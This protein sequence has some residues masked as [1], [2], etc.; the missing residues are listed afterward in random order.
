MAGPISG[1][2]VAEPTV[3]EETMRPVVR[4]TGFR[5]AAPAPALVAIALLVPLALKN[6]FV[7]GILTDCL[8]YVVLALSYDLS[9]GRIGALSLAQPAFFGTGAY[10]AAILVTH[11]PGAP[12]VLQVLLA[13]AAAAVLAVA[14]GIPAFRL[15][16]LTFGMATLGFAIIAELIAQ[17]EVGL[18]N[19]PLCV[20]GVPTMQ[21]SFLSSIG[22][23]SA[24]Q[25][26]EIFLVLAVVA[27]AFIWALVKSRIGRA[28]IAVRED[29]P[30]A[31]SVGINPKRY[32]MIAFVVGAAI[33]GLLGAFYA[34]YIS[35][36]C[37]TNLDISYTVSLLVI[38]FLGG[39]GGFWGIVL[40]AFVFTA[41][42]EILQ[43]D[44]SIRLIVYGAALLL[45][46][47]FLPEGF[48]GLFSRLRRRQARRK[49]P[50][51]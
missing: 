42:P 37:P 45:G 38:I 36:V 50:D 31:M 32:R 11:N 44:P 18:T 10:A 39:V 24:A 25:Q 29:E 40:A 47:T 8:V 20:A 16:H 28:F 48:E 9:V 33:A 22:M 27:G 13:I 14:I 5:R 6:D 21:S 34:H 7:L 23:D 43:L 49:V 30:M 4:W 19:G 1:S 35:V 12:L 3:P 15:N 51:A 2:S 17:N 41:I 46:I 26:Y